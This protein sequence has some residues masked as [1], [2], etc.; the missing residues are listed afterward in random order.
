M[1]AKST[2]KK[3]FILIVAMLVCFAVV[4]ASCNNTVP[5]EPVEMPA[6][7]TPSGNGGIAV[8]Y[9]EWLYYI[10]GYQSAVS[11][12]NTYAKAEP[13]VGSV[14][15]IKLSVIEQLIAITKKDASNSNKEKEIKEEVRKNAQTVIP[16]ISYT[17][18]TTTTALNGLW[19]FGNRIY[20][21][22]PNDALDNN[23]HKLTNQLVL[24]S[25]KLDGSDRQRHYVITSN[26]AQIMLSEV[27]G[28]VSATYVMDNAVYNLDVATASNTEV[29]KEISN[30]NFDI[31]GKAVVFTNKDGAILKLAAGKVEAKTVVENKIPE[32]KDT[33]PITYTIKSV[34]N[35]YVYYTQKNTDNTTLDDKV[36]YY[37][38]DS[39]S[40][41][42]A[43]N[44]VPSTSYGWQDKVVY[45]KSENGGKLYTIAVAS[46]NGSDAVNLLPV[47]QN[48]KQIK[49]DRLVGDVLYYNCDGISYTLDLAATDAEPKAYANGIGTS[50]TGGLLPDVVDI[51][52]SADKYIV[53]I[54]NNSVSLVRYNVAENTNSTSVNITLT[55]EEE[56][57]K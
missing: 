16:N 55:A 13:R 38:T 51:A 18:N 56:A 46:G 37:A 57:R 50:A 41:K 10:N 35:G 5:F 49:F 29:A 45:V 52:D 2:M 25:Y 36:L 6:D 33:S 34:N 28:N 31:A 39:E 30:V 44:Y 26:S 23:G 53:T 1:F 3:S 54:A 11:S 32:G 9:G 8:T 48:D 4:F 12:E 15:R 27:D 47:D 21:T 19:I 40:G 7:A 22:T 14:V 42:I 24:T 17:A 43:L 20:I